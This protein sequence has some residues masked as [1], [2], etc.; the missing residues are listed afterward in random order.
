[1]KFYTKGNNEGIFEKASNIG[2]LGL[3]FA[4]SPITHTVVNA[5]AGPNS[6]VAKA[7][8]FLQKIK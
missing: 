1:M 2:H 8:G 7:S 3:K 5:L 6:V 4:S